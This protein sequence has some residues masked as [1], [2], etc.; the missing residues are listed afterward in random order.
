MN[1]PLPSM[2][3]PRVSWLWIPIQRPLLYG[4]NIYALSGAIASYAFGLSVLS[5]DGS[6]GTYL[7][8]LKLP[9]SDE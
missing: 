9:F 5:V 2:L 1:G 4:L 8:D 3:Q 7:F 6:Q